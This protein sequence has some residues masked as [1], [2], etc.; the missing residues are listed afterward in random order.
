MKRE[1]KYQLF[2]KGED[3]VKR[4]YRY[5]I[6]Q[7][8]EMDCG[9]AALA[10]LLKKY[11]STISLAQLR[12]LAK[13]D[14]EG[15][16]AYGLIKAAQ[17]LNFETKA[18]QADMSLFE[19]KELTY[20]FIVHVLKN[21]T[22]LHYY[23][24]VRATKNYILIADPDP[25]V[26]V[27]KMSK[28]HFEKEWS[29]IEIFITPSLSYEPIKEKHQGLLALFAKLFKQT[30]LIVNIIIAAFLITLISII[31]SYFLQAIID[32]YIPNGMAKTLMLITLGLVII[33]IFNALFSYTRDFLL[34]ILGQ[35]LSIE[36]ILSYI[37][38][39]FE[40]PME[41]F[42]TRKTGE[43]I[44]RF[45]DASKIIDALAS[46]V[47]SMFLDVGIVIIMGVV[48]ALQNMTLFLLTLICLPLYIVII[49]AFTNSFE[50]LNQKQM[51]S[52]ALL[53]SSIIEDIQGIETVK[54]LNSE[55]QRYQ[56]ID[57]QFVDFLRK[58]LAY[59]K[60]D[61]LQQSIKGFIQH[62]LSV[63]ILWIGA[64]LVIE[65]HFS[66]GQLM[67]YNA[68]LVYFTDPL[69]NIIN[70]QPKLQSARVANTRLNEIYLVESE[71][72]AKRMS[73]NKEQ[74]QGPIL[75]TD[76]SY[77]YG[78][79]ADTL[80]Q[81]NL[82]I[83]LHEKVT[84]VGMSGSGKSTLVKLLVDFFEPN[85]GEITFNKHQ[86]KMIDK[87][88]LRSYVNY[89]PQTPYIFS[90]TV[91]EN[92]TLGSRPQ[93]TLDEIQKACQLAMIADDIEQMPLQYETKL[94]ENGSVL[95]GGQ[96]QRLTIARALLSPAEV[97]IFDESTSGLDMITERK[98][99]DNLLSL[100]SKTIIFIA[101][102]L[103]IAKRT[104]NIVV[105]DHGM[106]VEQGSHDRLMEKKGYY[107]RLVNT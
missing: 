13:T 84:I 42:S 68:L 74:L 35:R 4:F 45:N 38:H 54:S 81:I 89:V 63:V 17:T 44:S 66:L 98:L 50:R 28:R 72:K 77:R 5:Y 16:T 19:I 56:K 22:L 48:L 93:I 90:G 34:A 65:N 62:S 25:S 26:G 57:S 87:H 51:E 10:M 2:V 60:A 91:M 15:T 75:L 32:T 29:K 3:K 27:T 105:L 101:H 92:L 73:F 95:S 21:E 40:L 107:F 86:T 97:L 61:I 55:E 99:V 49:L 67:A 1:Y 83:K 69:Q 9:V 58:S 106:I 52:N 6:P 104:N 94:D 24:V 41:F 76:V 53:S 100:E 7:V 71:F 37:R 12:N 23:V 36:I 82:E 47:I 79:G 78:Y 20:P 88:C 14:L 33:Y 96:K 70:L 46:T 39:I 11:G 43:I 31:G 18:I 30:K 80:K 103:S 85:E 8:D 64:K 59:T 102:R